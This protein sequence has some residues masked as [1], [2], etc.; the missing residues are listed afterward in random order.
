MDAAEFRTAAVQLIDFITDYQENIRS[1]PVSPSVRPGYLRHLV[2]ASAPQHAETWDQ[3]MPDIERVIMPGMLHWHSPQ[4]HAYFAGATSYPSILADML[5]DALGCMG[6]SWASA[7]VLTEL[8]V[9]VMDWLGQMLQLPDE[10]LFSSGKGGGGNIQGSA[11]ESTLITML[12]AR[13]RAITRLRSERPEL[14][15]ADISGR[16]VGL[17]SDQ[18]HSSVARAGLLAG[19]RVRPVRSNTRNALTGEAVEA[20][21]A[22]ELA[23]GNIPFFVAATLGTTAS[24]AFDHLRNIGAVCARRALWLH[25]DAAYA[26]PAF[27]CPEF[28]PLLDGVELADSF[29]MN[30]HKFMLTAHDCSTL[31]VRRATDLTDV[32]HVDAKY[33]ATA[34][35]SMPSFRHW[36]IQLS[37][38]FRALKLWF[39]IRL[40]GVEGIRSYIRQQ[41]SLAKEFERLVR[42]DRRFEVAAPAVLGLVCFRLRDK[43]FG[44]SLT[45]AL[46][47]RV[48]A[49]RRVHMIP[50]MLRGGTQ[51]VIRFVVCSRYTEL[52]DVQLA[53]SEVQRHAD[54]LLAQPERVVRAKA[55]WG[56]VRAATGLGLL[57]HTNMAL[58]ERWNSTDS[59]SSAGEVHPDQLLF[60]CSALD[61]EASD[62]ESE[63]EPPPDGALPT[64]QP[65]P[66]GTEPPTKE[67]GDAAKEEN[68]HRDAHSDVVSALAS[69]EL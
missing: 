36:A 47:S 60:E 48:N 30:P 11:C 43:E 67:S 15:E 62:S 29:N 16:L 17:T 52:R 9:L 7:P 10:F 50:S 37:R 13:A 69:C 65:D 25:I 41:V 22:E 59:S 3:L 24:C 68:M 49:A 8:E 39:V 1:R 63:P 54:Q 18:A 66:A 6:I 64:Q 34:R 46:L 53:W 20:A 32:F 5:T 19:L 51:Y 26:G 61:S 27:I 58:F 45:D 40:Y 42:S 31:W 2:P 28:R 38:R 33:L 35:N 55:R 44:N 4:F 57:R 56:A 12:A 23:A 14:S 21:V